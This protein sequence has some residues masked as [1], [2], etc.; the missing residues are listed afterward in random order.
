MSNPVISVLTTVFNAGCFFEPSIRSIL[1]QTFR[2]FEFLIVD[3]ASTDGSAELAEAWAA[4]DPRIRVIRN[5]E[6]R[7]QTACLNQGLELARG[8]WIARQDADDLSHPSRF[9]KQHRF[10]TIQPDVVLLGTNGRII[11]HQD[12]LTGL[13]DAP[14]SHKSITWSS[15]FLNPFMH[16]SVVFRADIIRDTFGGY[17][18][19]Y[20]IAQDYELW[21]RV[22]AIHESANLSE[23]LV[24]YRHLPTSLSKAASITGFTEA[25]QVSAREARRVFGRTLSER[26]AELIAAF[27]EGLNPS[28]RRSFWRLYEELLST[29]DTRTPDLVRTVAMHH[30]KAAGALSSK[31]PWLALAEVFKALGTNFGATLGWLA[32]RYLNA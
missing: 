25:K 6:N 30:L 29:Q 18:Q 31:A 27:R 23:R 13:L 7:G 24:C 26:E 21:T 1:N 2:N 10:L 28:E 14:L 20:R 5:S 16:T 15:P 22:I 11:D 32:T 19:A 9:A 17:N 12:R 8:R 3:D 4:K